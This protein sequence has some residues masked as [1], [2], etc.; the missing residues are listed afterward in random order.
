[1]GAQQLV[2]VPSDEIQPTSIENK[3]VRMALI[4][5]LLIVVA[6]IFI[7]FGRVK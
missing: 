2:D 4:F 3:L 5:L 1:V 7:K 6:G